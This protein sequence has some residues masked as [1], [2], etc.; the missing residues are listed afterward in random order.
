MCL[1]DYLKS[2]ARINIKTIQDVFWAIDNQLDCVDDPDYDSD[3]MDCKV[4]LTYCT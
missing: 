2:K 3:H 4:I 1:S